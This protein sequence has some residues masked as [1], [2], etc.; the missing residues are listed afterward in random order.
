MKLIIGLGNP[1]EEHTGTRHNFGFETIDTL[2]KKLHASEFTFEKKFKSEI[3]SYQLPATNDQLLFVKPQTFMN[4]SG[5]AVS[6]LKSF[7]KVASEDILII[8]DE[9]DL[10]LGKMK[11]RLGGAAAGHHGVESVIKELGTDQFARLRLGIGT[12]QAFRGEHHRTSFNAEHFVID[13]FDESDRP[14]VKRM[15]KK[16]IEVVKIYIEDGL[17]KAQKGI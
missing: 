6:L 14:V 13:L 1:G 2:A 7:Y 15:I 10:P 5:I 3:T 8:H 11:L 17:E 4:N 16:A 9:L 12:T